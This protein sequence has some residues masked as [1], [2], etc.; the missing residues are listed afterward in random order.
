MTG[1]IRYNKP[2]RYQLAEDGK[3]AAAVEFGADPKGLQPVM[4][5]LE[6]ALGFDAEQHIYQVPRAKALPGAIDRRQ[7]LLG[8]DRPIPVRDRR[9]AIVAIAA[10]RMVGFPEIAEQNLPPAIDRFAISRECFDL[11]PL[12][13]ALAFGHLA[14]VEQPEEA[15]H[16]GHAVGHP[17]I[18]GEAVAP[19]ATG[20]LVISLE[21]LWRVEMSDEADI[22]LV[23]SHAKGDR[24][25]DDDAFLLQD[26]LLVALAH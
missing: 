20:L 5:E 1:D 18:G 2:L 13:A 26:A 9:S 8:R 12:D 6:D 15:C 14:V 25:D 19:G 24:C 10:G 21:I 3:P 17:G 4:P 16:I 23:D 11:L 22:G 7:G